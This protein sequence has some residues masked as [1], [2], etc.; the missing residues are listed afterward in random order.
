MPPT[1]HT[2]TV[3]GIALHWVEQGHGP[4]ILLL[5]GFPEFWYSWR[6]Q[7]DPLTAAGFRVVAPDMRGYNLSAKPSGVDEYRIDRLTADVAALIQ[8]V[9]NREKIVLAGHDWGGLVAW[10][11]AMAHPELLE[12]LIIFNCPHPLGFSRALRRFA[13]KKRSWYQY[14]FQIPLLPELILSVNHYAMIRRALSRLTRRREALTHSDLEKYV[15]AMKQPGAL[16]AMINYYR[17]IGRHRRWARSMVK[18]V[19]VPTLVVWGEK[20]PFFI[21]EAFERYERLVDRC[22]L[23]RVPGAGHFIQAD[24]PDLVIDRIIRFSRDQAAPVSIESRS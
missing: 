20:D 16:R 3:N 12:G 21:P 2:E 17:A 9:S 14:A 11:T 5:H 1:H 6:H 18:T 13:Q 8:H 23:E 10:F 19:T 4:V 7:I 24:L 15:E 22:E